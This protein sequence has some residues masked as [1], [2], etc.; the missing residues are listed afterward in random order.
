MKKCKLFSCIL[1]IF[2]V[3]SFTITSYA[4]DNGIGN[5]TSRND[6]TTFD[7]EFVSAEIMRNHGMLISP[8]ASYQLQDTSGNPTY[9]CVEFSYDNNSRVGY[10][11]VDLCSYDLVLYS[12]D[13]LPP[14]EGTDLVVYSGILDFAII[15]DD[16]ETAVDLY[17]QDTVDVESIWSNERDNL[18]VK[19][20]SDR[21]N[22]VNS[23][24][25]DA[26]TRSTEPE[27]A[28]AGSYDEILVYSAGNY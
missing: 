18:S 6:T 23:I 16:G 28:V 26:I 1:S 15:Q 24:S 3:L 19:S 10:G 12:I 7:E 13:K 25:S 4:A 14:F 8:A 20:V 9:T 2:L 21:E 22:I 17:T 11:I 27:I 5:G